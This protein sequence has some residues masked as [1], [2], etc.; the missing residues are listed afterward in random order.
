MICFWSVTSKTFIVIAY[1]FP[2][3]CV[4]DQLPAGAVMWM[5]FDTVS[6]HRGY[7]DISVNQV[8]SKNDVSQSRSFNSSN[9]SL[10]NSK[11]H[12][13][14]QRQATNTSLWSPWATTSPTKSS[15]EVTP[16]SR[17]AATTFLDSNPCARLTSTTAPW[18]CAARET[19]EPVATFESQRER[20]N[21]D[22]G[23]SWDGVEL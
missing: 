14:N 11:T 15:Q 18:R 3:C 10:A 1:K 13:S 9:L 21:K 8:L 12:P 22:S 6:K 4:E 23:T 16:P 19:A 20:W 2:P 7:I 17:S 5:L